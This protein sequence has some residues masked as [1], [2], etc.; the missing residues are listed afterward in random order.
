MILPAVVHIAKLTISSWSPGVDA[1]LF[2]AHFYAEIFLLSSLVEI[3]FFFFNILCKY[4]IHLVRN[5]ITV[6]CFCET[7]GQGDFHEI[8]KYVH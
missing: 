1:S 7:T 4:H 2:S 6:N 5:S 3:S 8:I